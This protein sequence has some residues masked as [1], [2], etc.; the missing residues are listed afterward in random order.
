MKLLYLIPLREDEI[1]DNP[2]YIS[3]LKTLFFNT[4]MA[5]TSIILQGLSNNSPP[6]SDVTSINIHPQMV[7]ELINAV[8]QVPIQSYDAII[9]GDVGFIESVNELKKLF[10]IPIIHVGEAGFLLTQFLGKQSIAITYNKKFLPW[11]NQII[12]YFNMS[13]HCKS[14]KTLDIEPENIINSNDVNNVKNKLISIINNLPQSNN[15]NVVILSSAGFANMAS[16]IREHVHIPV[17]DPVESA[18]KIA[19]I[20]ISMNK[21]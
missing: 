3:N 11:I 20:L 4:T 19:E 8:K 17:V 10:S 5:N 7:T 13:E 15:S 6:L 21:S 9:V 18:I 1:A 14:I 16:L 12:E 2:G